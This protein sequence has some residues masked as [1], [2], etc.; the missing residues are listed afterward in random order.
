[1]D[2]PREVKKL[3]KQEFS[4]LSFMEKRLIVIHQ[5]IGDQSKNPD[6]SHTGDEGDKNTS[7]ES[8]SREST[9]ADCDATVCVSEPELELKPVS[10][11]PES[12]H[13]PSRLGQDQ[14]YVEDD[15][16]TRPLS[17]KEEQL[18]TA[19]QKE[20]Y[21]D[22]Q[23]QEIEATDLGREAK[24]RLRL[25]EM[26]E[27][28]KL[29]DCYFEGGDWPKSTTTDSTREAQP[30]LMLRSLRPLRISKSTVR[31]MTRQS[32]RFAL[33]MSNTISRPQR[34]VLLRNKPIRPGEAPFA[35]PKRAVDAIARDMGMTPVELLAKVDEE[36][37]VA[38]LPKK[39]ILLA[40]IWDW[41]PPATQKV[42]YS[43]Y[44]EPP[45]GLALGYPEAI[46]SLSGGSYLP[47]YVRRRLQALL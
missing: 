10:Y 24:Y 17:T 37:I 6:G 36:S 44:S 12:L 33:S 39:D 30:N 46:H 31:M 14:L 38:L 28:M 42:L 32:L 22:A 25:L 21:G 1:L 13:N 23:L 40:Q 47:G 45:P 7:R 26:T 5:A 9:E 2:L 11:E 8:T 27:N 43:I 20:R 41:L 34:H 19:L 18:R 29:G 16:W 35:K 15:F 3:Q 4:S